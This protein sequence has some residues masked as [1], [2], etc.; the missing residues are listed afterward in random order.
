MKRALDLFCGAGGLSEGFEKAGFEIIAAID[1][2]K[3]A[4]FTY[5]FNHPKT[6][7]I[8]NDIRKINAK[9]MLEGTGYHPDDIDVIIGG[10][11]CEGFSTVGYRRPNDPR[12][13]LFDEFLR[14]VSE[15]QPKAI[16]IENVTGLLSMEKG[17]VV[18]KVL[19]I[20]EKNGYK[21]K[22][23]V[24]CAADFGV[25]QKRERVFFIGINTGKSPTFPKPTHIAGTEQRTL[26]Q[27]KLFSYV[28]VRDAIS[29]L[30]PLNAGEGR[31]EAT[32]TSPPLTPYQKERRAN[33]VKLFNHVAPNHS[34]LV[35][36]RIK[37]IPPGG[38]HSDL[39]PH[40]RLKSGYPN[41]YGRLKWD[42]PADTITG[43]CGCVSAPGR[44]IHP[45][46]NRVI[47][48]REAARL[49]SFDDNYR[50]FGTKRSQYKQVGDAVPPLLAKAIASE[51][52]RRL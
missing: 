51:L 23:K 35:L 24:L 48:V 50:F 15:I 2:D 52:L 14:I 13:T 40:L 18:K 1:H 19:D 20:L 4:V 10:P 28:T 11:P 27:E 7:V 6:K 29:D 33:S 31:E 16:V 32:Y 44:F 43:N 47:T 25:P 38:N 26:F 41:I 46:D 8:L 21:A 17:K 34:P 5:R 37:L 45:R 39:P 42:E 12:N 22:F 9:Q 3:D 36:Q 30:P 49:Q